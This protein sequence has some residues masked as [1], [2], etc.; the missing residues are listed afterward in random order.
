M[1]LLMRTRVVQV[2]VFWTVQRQVCGGEW[3]TMRDLFCTKAEASKHKHYW[4]QR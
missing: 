3:E 1:V 4:A 2:G